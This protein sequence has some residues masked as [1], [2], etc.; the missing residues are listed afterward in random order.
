MNRVH[1]QRT[2]FTNLKR[3]APGPDEIV[4]LSDEDLD[5]TF[6]YRAWDDEAMVYANNMA[7]SELM[8]DDAKFLREVAANYGCDI[9]DDLIDFA[10]DNGLYIDDTWYPAQHVKRMMRENEQ[11]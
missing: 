7:D 11:V 1:I 5:E 10:K 3:L 8:F 4:V 2:R 6:G 9:L